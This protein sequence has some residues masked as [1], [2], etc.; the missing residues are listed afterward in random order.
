MKL[1]LIRD[2]RGLTLIEVCASFAILAIVALV[3]VQGFFT[4][5]T[6]AAKTEEVKQDDAQL[7]TEIIQGSTFTEEDATLGLADSGGTVAYS[8]PVTVQTYTADNGTEI[9][10]F[11]DA[12]R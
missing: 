4:V 6:I 7:A 2:A 5:G 12:L 1:P 9:K 11:L 8:I 3:L 10:V